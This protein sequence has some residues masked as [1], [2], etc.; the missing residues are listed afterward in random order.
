MADPVSTG[1]TSAAPPVPPMPAGTSLHELITPKGPADANGMFHLGSLELD[2]N[3]LAVFQASQKALGGATGNA[4]QLA[5]LWSVEHGHLPESEPVAKAPAGTTV[6]SLVKPAGGMTPDANGDI[7]LGRLS[8]KP[9][10][11]PQFEALQRNLAAKNPEAV[12]TLYKLENGDRDYKLNLNDVG[13]NTFDPSKG[14]VIS[15]DPHK[16]LRDQFNK[17]EL[18]PKVAGFHEEGHATGSPM[19]SATL[20]GIPDK[21]YSNLEEKRVIEG[22]EA[23][24]MAILGLPP[25]H[26]H[27][28]AAYPVPTIDSTKPELTV[29]QNGK[30]HTVGAG[31]QQTG[32][33]AGTDA[34]H[35]SIDVGRGQQVQLKTNELAGFMGSPGN[36]SAVL[37][38][39]KAHGD[40]ATFAISKDGKV[41]YEN[42]QQ[43]QRFFE[44]QNQHVDPGYKL[45]A[46]PAAVESPQQARQPAQSAGL[47]R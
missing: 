3:Q 42:P 17:S 16:D 23:R 4:E 9:A 21:M 5:T 12:D 22:P 34:N 19:V 45:L 25:R 13:N 40:T 37:N 14:N 27:I 15:W 18:P 10:D 1:G 46:T 31:Y 43:L 7:H 29:T 39:A 2:K 38:D 47:E 20:H 35:V 44:A 26:S 41:T 24:E 6:D 30:D 28:G 33:I 36:A 8:L 11:L 32:K